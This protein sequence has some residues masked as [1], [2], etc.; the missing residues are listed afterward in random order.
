MIRLL[1]METD[2]EVAA[3]LDVSV[4]SVRRKRWLLGIP[5]Y[6]WRGR[7][8][9][10]GYPWQPEEIAL[11]GKVSDR[12]LAKQLGLS[13]STV[14]NKRIRLS[15]APWRARPPE[16]AWTPAMHRLLGK[17]PDQA[18]A[19]RYSISDSSVMQERRRRGIR[20]V[21]DR[22]G[23]EHTPELLELLKLPP[24]EV[25]RRTGLNPGTIAALKRKYNIKSAKVSELRYTPE[26][27]SRL[28]TE[29]DRAIAADLEVSESAVRQK[30]HNLGIPAY[31]RRRRPAKE[32]G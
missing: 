18:I 24:S 8:S 6:G 13:T 3:E 21:M 32:D 17:I 27:T 7:V 1:G 11:L 15:I 29:P 9:G 10:R 2:R 30:R 19:R 12:S 14:A 22:R 23:I 28:G 4:H 31:G 26:I 5:A 25:R 20:P 16:V